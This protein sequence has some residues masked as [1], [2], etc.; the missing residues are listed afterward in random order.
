LTEGEYIVNMTA[1]CSQYRDA[2]IDL[3]DRLTNSSSRPTT[4]SYRSR[5]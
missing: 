1:Q 3:R 5:L 4:F 2:G